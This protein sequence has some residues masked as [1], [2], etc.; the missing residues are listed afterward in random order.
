MERAH[1]WLRNE[2]GLKAPKIGWQLDPFGHS[3][4]NAAIFA[5]LGFEVVVFQ[6]INAKDKISRRATKDL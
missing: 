1:D 6:R 2:F 4:A 3:A 5:E